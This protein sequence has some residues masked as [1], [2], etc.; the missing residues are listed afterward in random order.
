MRRSSSAGRPRASVARTSAPAGST[1]RLDRG[2]EVQPGVAGV[3][4][5]LLDPGAF[6]DRRRSQVGQPGRDVGLGQRLIARAL[7]LDVKLLVADEIISM[8]DASTR[9]D[10]LN[11]LIGLKQS[12]LAI[13]FITHDLS[14]G[15]YVSDRT[16]ILRHGAV[17]E[18]GDTV[19]VFG[20]PR[21]P[22]TQSLLAAVPELHKKW[23][24]THGGACGHAAGGRSGAPPLTEYEPG[25]LVA[26]AEL[27]RS[28]AQATC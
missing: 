10:I 24:A 27:L 20:N 17:V 13:L 3:C 19:K 4:R 1:G 23:T 9:V 26:G 11:L 8:L 5:D 2:R 7:L 15:N 22:Y 18:M 12:G 6:P 14:L 25:H 16:V 21:H 28:Y